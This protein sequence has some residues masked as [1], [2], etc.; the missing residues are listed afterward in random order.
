MPHS[1][2]RDRPREEYKSVSKVKKI[3]IQTI[4]V[5]ISAGVFY[6]ILTYISGK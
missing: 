3:I 1:D 2:D 4:I 5:L 6:W